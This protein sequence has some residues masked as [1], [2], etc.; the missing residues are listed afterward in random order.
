MVQELLQEGMES[1]GV[2][3]KAPEITGVGGDEQRLEGRDRGSRL[4]QRQ[5][6][7]LCQGS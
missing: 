3:M 1:R 5:L 2:Q 4:C 7:P 6:L